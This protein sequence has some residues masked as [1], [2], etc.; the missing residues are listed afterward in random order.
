MA[1]ESVST[2]LTWLCVPVR[3]AAREG[4]QIELVT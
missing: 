3:I 1:E 2:P 4:V